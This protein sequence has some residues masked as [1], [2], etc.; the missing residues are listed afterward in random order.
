MA[1]PTVPPE[2]AEM[3]E[4]PPAGA[5]EIELGDLY[6]R[7]LK[8]G[9]TFGPH[10][11]GLR[12]SWTVGEELYSEVWLPEEYAEETKEFNL[13]PA[14]LDAAM[15]VLILGASEYLDDSVAVGFAWSGVHLYATGATALRVRMLPTD[16]SA[17]EILLADQHGR[18]VAHVRAMAGRAMTH[19]QADAAYHRGVDALLGVTWSPLPAT[20]AP[21]LTVVET[22]LGSMSDVDT[23][24]DVVVLDVRGDKGL[25]VADATR[26]VTHAALADLQTWSG[27]ERFAA[28]RLV[29]VTDGAQGLAGEAVTD[30]PAAAVVGMVRSVQ[31]ENP[32]R[33][34]LID[35]HA[36]DRHLLPGFLASQE[37]QVVVRDGTGHM[38]RLTRLRPGEKAAVF[39]PD[40]TVLITGGTGALGALTAR[41][42]VTE[43][44][45]R[46]LL[47]TSRRGADAPGAEELRA[48]LTELGAQVAIA[49]CDAA[50]RDALAAVLASIPADH[51]LTAVIHTAGVTDDGVL[52]SL[53]PER[54]DAVLRPKVDAVWNLHELTKNLDLGAFV[55]FSSL[56]GVLGNPGQANYAAANAFL[57]AL[58]AHR[59]A[60]GLPAVSLAWGPW[61]LSAGMAGKLGDVERS[62]MARSGFLT[63]S[64]QEG[65]ARLDAALLSEQDSVV[66]LKL[67]TSALAALGSACPPL[68]RSMVRTTRRNAADRVVSDKSWAEALAGKEGADRED[69]LR[70]LVAAEVAASLGHSTVDDVD[71]DRRF[72]EMGFD[73]LASVE[74]RNRLSAATEVSLPPTLVFDHPDV[75][76]MV[77]YLNTRLPAVQRSLAG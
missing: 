49:A 35:I 69:T 64:A 61:A 47:L 19:E 36:A 40:G 20:K 77:S 11:R 65:M 46:H 68:F 5:R 52:A 3:T 28:S 33:I 59:R 30:L 34:T 21:D 23:V 75:A 16:E 31:S 73:S 54:F 70:E 1:K 24:P 10:F 17:V 44:G 26:A 57:D 56:A 63:L 41:H 67:D 76:S 37:Q 72:D 66:P 4:W 74:L 50:D 45:V 8:E 51:P 25:P 58:A 7:F 55:L 27:E 14:L 42:L 9:Y 48:E 39:A 60:A 12:H 15:H 71:I 29:V 13:H 62:R 2:H 43:H 6:D 53:T 18:P 22:S 38:G 32:G